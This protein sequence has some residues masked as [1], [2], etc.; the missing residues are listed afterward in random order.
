MNCKDSAM[1]RK[2][3]PGIRGEQGQ[4]LLMFVLF[5]VVLFV[6]IGLGVDLGF[7]YITRSK[8]SKAVDSACL[9]GMR[10]LAQGQSAAGNAARAAF[11]A[12]YGISGRDVAPPTVTVTFGTV[13]K[14][15]VIDV[16]ATVSI[17]TYFIRVLPLWKTLAVGSA[18]EATRADVIMTLVLDRSGS[19]QSNGGSTALPPAV[20]SFISNFDDVNDIAAMVSFA[21]A[22]SVDVPMQR[23]FKTQIENAA[24]ALVFN[25]NTCSDEGLT[26]ALPQQ[27][28]VTI[29][30]GQDVIK[31][32]VFFTDGMANTF[33][34]NL[35]C[36]PRNMSY[37]GNLFDPNT[38]TYSSSGCT[39]PNPITSIDGSTLVNTAR[40]GSQASCDSMHYEAQKRA[41]TWADQARS[42]T[43][44]IYCVG[45]GNPGGNNKG[46]CNDGVFPILNPEFLK[47]VANTTDSQTYNKN[48][49]VGDYA[50][51]AN[52]AQLQDAFDTIA[53]KILLRLSK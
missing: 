36:G 34:Y 22:A 10:N 43:N 21:G 18:A 20:T 47:D 25:F 49:P 11:A 15:I 39:V 52:A 8:L 33:N 17:N 44:F 31:V 48:Q 3:G 14:N 27:N 40:D 1:R 35:N 46:E 6:F 42:Q 32:I 7:A 38:G 50:V 12:N 30:P 24:N 2:F 23:P 13:N 37:D 28:S 45:L 5:I 19:M 53:R 51:A 9:T 4:T 41:E 29:S 16:G 26:N